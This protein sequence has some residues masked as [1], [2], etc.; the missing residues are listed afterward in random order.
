[1]IRYL[2]ALLAS[3][4][5][6]PTKRYRTSWRN[7]CEDIQSLPAVARLNR[8]LA[9]N[10]N[11]KLSALRTPSG[12]FNSSPKEVGELMLHVHFPGCQITNNDQCTPESPIMATIKPNWEL[13]NRL[14]TQEVLQWSIFSFA[15]FKSSGPDGIFLAEL[16]NGFPLIKKHICFTFFK[17]VLL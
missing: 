15:P 3:L 9:K 14:I 1:M 4:P 8:A 11:C 12:E 13:A 16:Q 2:A 10:D 7:F 6:L 5:S 17:H